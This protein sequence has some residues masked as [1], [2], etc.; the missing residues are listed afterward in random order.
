MRKLIASLLGLSILIASCGQGQLKPQ[1]IPPGWIRHNLPDGWIVYLP[2]GF[3]D[4][5]LRDAD[6]GSGYLL[7]TSENMRLRLVSRTDVLY[8]Q[9]NS[10]RCRLSSQVALAEDAIRNDETDYF[11]KDNK[12]FRQRIDTIAGRIAIIKTPVVTG[13]NWVSVSISDCGSGRR[14]SISGDSLSAAQ[15]ARALQ[16]F[17]TIGLSANK[18]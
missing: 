5:L 3:T 6:A 13:R 10:K 14:L 18:P 2:S 9:A 11:G 4:S 17:E 12:I 7:S 16:I 1:V 15:E 8:S